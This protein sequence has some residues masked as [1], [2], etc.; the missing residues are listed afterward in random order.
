MRPAQ[1]HLPH[2]GAFGEAYAIRPYAGCSAKLRRWPQPPPAPIHLRTSFNTAFPISRNAAILI[3]RPVFLS[4]HM[5]L[6]ILRNCSSFPPMTP[7]LSVS[8]LSS[9]S[10]ATI[11]TAREAAFWSAISSSSSDIS[12]ARR[13]KSLF[14]A[15]EPASTV[16]FFA[17]ITPALFPSYPPPVYEP[18][19]V[20]APR[21]GR[22]RPIA[23]PAFPSVS[24]GGPCS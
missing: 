5:A 18:S 9:F 7:A 24:L 17:S 20:Q 6:N 15:S 3:N 14:G 13:I 1:H 23:H 16:S 4:C 10:I 22:R 21:G 12:A 8:P 11:T 19:P 2:W